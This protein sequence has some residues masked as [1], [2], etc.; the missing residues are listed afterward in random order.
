RVCID[1]LFGGDVADAPALRERNLA[2]FN[3]GNRDAGHAHLL[4]KL[5]DALLE[6]RR[7]RGIRARSSEDQADCR[8]QMDG[9]LEH[10]ITP[11]C[12]LGDVRVRWVRGHRAQAA[13][14][15]PS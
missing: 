12:G 4:P 3:D 13:T 9:L 1:R 5:L 7:G 8:S 2:V 11:G 6:A 15:P 14:R 10:A